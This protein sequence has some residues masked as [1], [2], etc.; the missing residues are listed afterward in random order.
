MTSSS[1]TNQL[2][3]LSG[4]NMPAKSCENEQQMDGSP[5]CECGKGM[6]DCLIHPSTP[7]KWIASMQECML[8][9]NPYKFIGV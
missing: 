8:K 2:S 4:M 1:A 7:E 6:S 5:I 3:L 9:L